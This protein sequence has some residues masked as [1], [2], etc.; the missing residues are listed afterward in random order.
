[1][2]YGNWIIGVVASMVPWMVQAQDRVFDAPQPADGLVVY[3]DFEPAGMA[4]NWADSHRSTG[5]NN[6]AV[7]VR[8]ELDRHLVVAV[9]HELTRERVEDARIRVTLTRT[10]PPGSP[11]SSKLELMERGAPA[12]YG[13]MVTVDPLAEY[14]LELVISRPG[15]AEP[16]R[17]RFG[18]AR[19]PA[20]G[21]HGDLRKRAP[22]DTDRQ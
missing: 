19:I 6:S 16:S 5:A 14:S 20:T 8:P 1:M 17:L 11:F 2:S 21:S 13:T 10:D 7:A 12:T 18:P 4:R 9:V 15:E 22:P 3:V